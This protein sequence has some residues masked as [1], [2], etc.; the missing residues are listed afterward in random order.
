MLKFIRFVLFLV[1]LGA[2]GVSGWWYLHS[3]QDTRA[4]FRTVPAER[5]ELLATISATGTIEPEEVID[6]GAQVA[7]IIK[8]LGHD[9]KNP[10]A[11][12]DYRSEVEEGTIL[13]KIDVSLYQAAVEQAAANMH[14]AEANVNLA[15]ANLLAM[16]SK[17]VQTK[18]DWDRV[19][20]LKPTKALSDADFDTAQ[21]AWETAAAAVPGG[22]AAVQ[23]AEKAVEVA[24]ANLK[25]AQ[26]NLAYC[27]IRS[28]VKGVI[29]DRRVNIGQTVVSSLSAPS[30][31]LLAKDLHR[32]QV[33]A[34]VNEADIGHLHNGQTVGFSVDAFPGVRFKGE[35]IQIR[36]NATM[37]Q[38]VVTYTVVVSTDNSDGRLYPYMTANLDFEIERKANALRVPN[39]A[40][41]WQPSPQQVSTEF[42]A[43]FAKTLR[44]AS[45]GGGGGQAAAASKKDAH[46]HGRVWVEDGAFVRPVKVRIGLSDGIMTEITAGELTEGTPVIVGEIHESQ[47]NDTSNPFTPQ[48]FKKGS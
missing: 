16:N 20:V 8:E 21:N 45:G 12:I 10:N 37:T 23:A 35:V 19:Q 2:F 34:S 5:G 32:I 6:I 4:K 7:G 44:A 22:E 3:H 40:L 43:E 31:F 36:L 30:L 27:T 41:R 39:S 13:A 25:T 1:L 11:S 17:L 14:Q 24:K 28:P 48:M 47:G 46:E 9:P 33:W 29:I 26:I 18:R 38:N 42:R 15:K